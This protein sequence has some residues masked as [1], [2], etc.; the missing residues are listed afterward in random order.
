MKSVANVSLRGLKKSDA[1]KLVILANNKSVANNLRD[2]FPSPYN[3][4]DA[5][6]FIDNCLKQNPTTTFA[7]EY[8]GEYVGNIGLHYGIDIYRK[9]AEIGY[10]IGEAYWNKGITSKAIDLI[11][12]YGFDTLNIVRIYAGVFAFNHASKRV[13]EKCKYTLE[14]I[15]KAAVYK[16]NQIWDE[17]RFSKINPTFKDN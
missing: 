15:A 9:S 6:T 5:K 10:F 12:S 4:S 3:L 16:N 8:N 11:T 7:I 2:A 1:E 13:L 17:Y 14:N